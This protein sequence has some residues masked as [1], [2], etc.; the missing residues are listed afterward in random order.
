MKSF[1][2]ECA[3]YVRMLKDQNGRNAM[4]KYDGISDEE[5]LSRFRAGEQDIIDYIMEKYKN[6]VRKNAKA[7][8][9]LGGDSEDL[10]QEGMIGLFKA[11]RDYRMD[12]ETSFYSFAD[13]CISRQMYS[14][15]T[16]DRRMKHMPLNTYISLYAKQ[17]NDIYGDNAAELIE[18][19]HSLYIDNPETLVISQENAN[20]LQE[21]LENNLSKFEQE[22]IVLYLAGNNY[23][24]I[25]KL[26]DRTP[27]SID[28]AL[29]RIRT[30]MTHILNKSYS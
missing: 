2:R 19:L 20:I 25:A 16:A 23:T 11:V 27:K 7:M 14:A 6:L 21:K 17:E 9:L 29:Q 30:K 1:A 26:M 5:L 18:Q 22:V 13:L 28:N 3:N 24:Q 4:E 10:I 12:K 8:Y 15:V